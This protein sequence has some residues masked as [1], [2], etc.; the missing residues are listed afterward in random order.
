MRRPSELKA[1]GRSRRGGFVPLELA[2]EGIAQRGIGCRDARS[3]SCVRSEF[4]PYLD[5]HDRSLR[6]RLN[7]DVNE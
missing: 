6:H 2:D 5:P 4:N 1:F 3:E 7:R